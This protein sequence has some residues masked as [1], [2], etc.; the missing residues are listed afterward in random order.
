MAT[1]TRYLDSTLSVDLGTPYFGKG[2]NM[3]EEELVHPEEQELDNYDNLDV[4]EG[5]ETADFE[6]EEV[7][8]EDE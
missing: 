3:S 2:S 1:K 4:E 5:E 8:D 6:A 7:S